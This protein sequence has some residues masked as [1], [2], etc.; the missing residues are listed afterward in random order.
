MNTLRTQQDISM[1]NNFPKAV[2]PECELGHVRH[3]SND[4]N[5]LFS[6]FGSHISSMR[7]IGQIKS[8]YVRKLW[9][10]FSI[11]VFHW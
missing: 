4:K 7:I 5:H 10:H 1:E 2:V 8:Y 3:V 11:H 6:D 9:I